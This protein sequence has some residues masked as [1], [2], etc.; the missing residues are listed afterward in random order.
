VQPQRV[1]LEQR[2]GTKSGNAVQ[3]EQ[4]T[5]TCC[6]DLRHPYERP[7]LHHCARKIE[8]WL[9]EWNVLTSTLHC[10]EFVAEGTHIPSA[11]TAVA[12]VLQLHVQPAQ[13]QA[14]GPCQTAMDGS[15]L[16]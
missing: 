9:R 13:V 3:V 15:W 8:A 6:T 16:W 11:S 2:I 5:W 12:P 14:A 7:T 4:D 10:L 1:C